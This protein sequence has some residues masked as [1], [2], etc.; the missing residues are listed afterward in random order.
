MRV[1]RCW[2]TRVARAVRLF[3]DT[4]A[5]RGAGLGTA[6][7]Q[8]VLRT[9]GVSWPHRQRALQFLLYVHRSTVIRQREKEPWP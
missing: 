3:I 4:A 6:S 8:S 1:G 9:P 5:R 2:T 7:R